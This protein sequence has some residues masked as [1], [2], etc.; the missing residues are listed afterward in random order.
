VLFGLRGGAAEECD[1]FCTGNGGAAL[2]TSLPGACPARQHLRGKR[3]PAL[4]GQRTTVRLRLRFR[5]PGAG[6]EESKGAGGGANTVVLGRVRE[7]SPEDL[8]L[9]AIYAGKREGL[10]SPIPTTIPSTSQHKCAQFQ[11]LVLFSSDRQKF[12]IKKR[13]FV[14]VK[15]EI[16][17]LLGDK[18]FS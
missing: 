17:Y 8:I 18:L 9:L 3:G 14:Q 12:V 16:G 4:A 6:I 13:L 2:C 5:R 11:T 10:A 1:L 15:W 7:S